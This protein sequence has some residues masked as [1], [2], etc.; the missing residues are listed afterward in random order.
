[1]S[2]VELLRDLF[3]AEAGFGNDSLDAL[4]MSRVL[5]W[6]GIPKPL[7]Q[8]QRMVQDVDLSGTGKLG[9]GNFE[10]FMRQVL[11][12]EGKRRRQIFQ[13][14]DPYSKGFILRSE[15]SEAFSKILNMNGSLPD[16]GAIKS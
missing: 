3:E 9:F 10:K 4:S 5:R 16:E 2:E 6:Y 13:I 8:V 12:V 11:H 15:L 1:M 7:Q 14:Y